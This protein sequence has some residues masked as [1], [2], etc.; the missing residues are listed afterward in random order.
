MG[1]GVAEGHRQGRLRPR[2]LSL[3]GWS[4]R[5][6]GKQREWIETTKRLWSWRW[7]TN[8]RRKSRWTWSDQRRPAQWCTYSLKVQGQERLRW[9]VA[10][11]G[12][13][14]RFKAR[15]PYRYPVPVRSRRAFP[16]PWGH[17]EA[18]KKGHNTEEGREAKK[19]ERSQTS[20]R[21]PTLGAAELGG[22]PG[23]S[24]Y[25]TGTCAGRKGREGLKNGVLS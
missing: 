3:T 7:M 6:K 19:V 20:R 10:G 15:S 16:K 23:L 1:R 11:R 25:V 9:K 5:P 8:L 24:R 18:R 14:G 2:L 13:G 12:H 22:G 4:K 17:E 21:K